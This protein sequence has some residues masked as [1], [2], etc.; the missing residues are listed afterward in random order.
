MLA[1]AVATEGDCTF[2]HVTP[3]NINKKFVG[4]SEEKIK[5]IF[6]AARSEKTRSNKNAVIFIDEIDSHCNARSSGDHQV[7]RSIK[8]E[9]LQQMQG[10]GASSDG[11]LVLACTNIPWELDPAFLRRFVRHIYIGL[12]DTDTRRE[13][14]EKLLKQKKVRNTLTPADLMKL[15]DNTPG[16]SGDDIGKVIVRATA[17]YRGRVIKATHFKKV[18]GPSLSDPQVDEHDFKKECDSNDEGAIEMEYSEE[19][20]DKYVKLLNVVPLEDFNKAV[21]TTCA[22]VAAERIDRYKKFNPK[23]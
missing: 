8:G 10:V 6:E 15:A 3:A 9:L 19:P 11:I 1:K 12:P 18:S 16:F 13:M 20:G 17:M 23:V 14:F 5:E 22:S 7:A 2:H 4:E 21:E